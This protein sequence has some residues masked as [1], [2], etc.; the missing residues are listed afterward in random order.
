MEEELNYLS[1]KIDLLEDIIDDNSHLTAEAMRDI[2]IIENVI[3]YIT[4][5]EL[6][7]ATN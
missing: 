6:C 5:K 3:K 7:E 1:S 2:E 4:L